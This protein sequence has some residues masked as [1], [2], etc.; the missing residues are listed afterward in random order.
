MAEKSAF[1]ETYV[2]AAGAVAFVA[3]I[4]VIAA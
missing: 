3:I 1:H 4:D 2:R